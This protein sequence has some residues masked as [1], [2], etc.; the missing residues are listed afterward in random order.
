MHCLR[1]TFA[2][3]WVENGKNLKVLQEILGHQDFCMT[4]SMYVHP[5]DEQA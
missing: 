5:T 2:T 4:M 3:R 1:H